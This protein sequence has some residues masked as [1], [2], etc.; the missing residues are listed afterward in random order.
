[1]DSTRKNQ[2]Q[3]SQSKSSK[4]TALAVL[5]LAVKDLADKD[6]EIRSDAIKFFMTDG[7]LVT[8]CEACGVDATELTSW[9]S[10]FSVMAFSF[11]ITKFNGSQGGCFEPVRFRIL[12]TKSG[13]RSARLSGLFTR[14]EE[15]K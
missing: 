8:F 15:E 13:C 12:C 10:T 14:Q 2:G 4:D 5:K 11:D 6:Q 9:V 3:K 7:G 1:M